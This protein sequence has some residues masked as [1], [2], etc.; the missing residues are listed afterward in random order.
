MSRGLSAGRARG[1]ELARRLEPPETEHAGE[2]E[3]E[4]RPAPPPA[5]TSLDALEHGDLHQAGESTPLVGRFP[6]GA[7]RMP[8]TGL[9]LTPKSAR[10]ARGMCRKCLKSGEKAVDLDLSP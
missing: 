10:V 3:K 7:G 4:E 9:S 2:E 6:L 8:P 1:P 5:P